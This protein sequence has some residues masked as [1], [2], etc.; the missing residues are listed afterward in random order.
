MSFKYWIATLQATGDPYS[1]QLCQTDSVRV[2]VCLQF[3]YCI[4]SSCIIYRDV[5]E[6][7][8]ADTDAR[9]ETQ[10]SETETLGLFDTRPTEASCLLFETKPTETETLQL[11]RPARNVSARRS[12]PRPET[13]LRE[14]FRAETETGTKR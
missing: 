12:G 3:G 5:Y 11:S 8:S 10:V 2:R 6:T 14:T 7:F 9:L 4:P 13:R 1:Q